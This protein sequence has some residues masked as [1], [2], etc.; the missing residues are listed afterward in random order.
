MLLQAEIFDPATDTFEPAAN[1]SNGGATSAVQLQDGR[2]LITGGRNPSGIPVLAE[3]YDPDTDSFSPTTGNMM[4]AR[5]GHASIRLPGG[6]ILI[7]GGEQSS[8][9]PLNS[10]EIYDPATGMFVLIADVMGDP[11]SRPTTV[12]LSD[13]NVLIAGGGK[14]LAAI[15]HLATADI[16]YPITN[17]ILPTV[18]MSIGRSQHKATRLPDGRVLVAGG[19]NGDVGSTL[20][21]AELFEASD[22]V[23][24][25]DP[26]GIP[27][28]GN[29]EGIAASPDGKTV[30]VSRGQEI[31]V[32]NT[33]TNEIDDTIS[34][35]YPSAAYQITDLDVHPDGSKLYV[36]A[37]GNAPASR[38]NVLNTSDLHGASVLIDD[39][40]RQLRQIRVPKNDTSHYIAMGRHGWLR[41]RTSDNAVINSFIK[42]E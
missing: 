6:K 39:T 13:G 17:T 21:S 33:A 35:N 20:D 8:S 30:Y 38:I 14:G 37:L 1:M 9:T 32:I 28:A 23:Q 5:E 18:A 40:V 41:I 11:R 42:T 2:V 4:V 24:V 12:L 10:A 36:V 25:G 26:I 22:L 29:M 31:L 3:I 15:E 7:A 34:L 16:Y 19:Y 27:G